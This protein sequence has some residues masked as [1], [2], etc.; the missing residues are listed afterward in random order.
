ML[1]HLHLPLLRVLRQAPHHAGVGAGGDRE[2]PREEAGQGT[3]G[4]IPPAAATRKKL[5]ALVLVP[6]PQQPS[7]RSCCGFG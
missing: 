3:N 4:I 6:H 1:H 5:L 7:P 2:A